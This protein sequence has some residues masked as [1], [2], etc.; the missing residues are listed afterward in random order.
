MDTAFRILKDPNSNGLEKPPDISDQTHRVLEILEGVQVSIS[1]LKKAKADAQDRQAQA[2]SLQQ[3]SLAN[4]LKAQADASEAHKR[5][6]DLK[7]GREFARTERARTKAEQ[8]VSGHKVEPHVIN[9]DIDRGNRRLQ[10]NAEEAAAEADAVVA[11]L[12][13]I[14]DRHCDEL[15]KTEAAVSAAEVAIDQAYLEGIALRMFEQHAILKGLNAELP[16]LALNR[17]SAISPVRRPALRQMARRSTSRGA[18]CIPISCC[19]KWR[20]RKLRLRPRAGISSH[21]HRK[22]ER[23]EGRSPR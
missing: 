10:E 3:Q 19:Q 1:P 21:P 2:E 12:Q 13:A 7:A 15:Q 23:A 16:N 4:V 20:L 8:I 5:L 11:Q 17:S 18:S 9:F 22:G 14:Y 6:D